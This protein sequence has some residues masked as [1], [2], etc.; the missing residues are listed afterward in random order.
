MKRRAPAIILALLAS[1]LVPIMI[2][3]VYASGCT[4]ACQVT[5]NS[6]VPAADGTIWIKIDNGTGTYCSGNPCTVALPQSTPPT[7]NFANNTI[8]TITVLN[9]TFTGPSTQGHYI[10]KEWANYYGTSSQTKWTSNT[11]IVIGP[12][13]YNYT[14]TAG[15]TTVFDRQYPATLSFTDVKGNPLSPSPVS[16]TLQGRATGTTTITGYSGQYVSADLYTV[17]S[18][19]WEGTSILAN[20]TE[21]L[22]LTNGPATATISLRAYP[23]TVLIVDNNNNPVSGANVTITFVNGTVTSKTYVSGSNGKV[24]LGDI[25][26]P[27][28]YGVTVHY[29]NQVYGPYSVTQTNNPTYTI[30]V[31]A[32]TPATTTT[33]AI[34]LLAIF[35]IAFFLILLAI[36]VR[37]P[38]APPTIS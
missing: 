38:A 14:G 20:S 2:G 24:N 33:T 6:N 34:V 4:T 37:K 35:G 18:A 7:F 17:T 9:N 30:K 36:R 31:S 12:I 8:H 5:V 32:S 21:T 25:P 29:Q 13:L 16:L 27:G 23:A 10:W 28:S 3:N 1:F 19:L 11:M 15:F 22:D 26:D